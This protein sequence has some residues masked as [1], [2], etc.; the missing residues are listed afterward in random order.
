M[1]E[2]LCTTLFL[3]VVAAGVAVVAWLYLRHRA[4]HTVTPE[5]PY[6]AAWRAYAAARGYTLTV[7]A[8]T[9][10][11]HLGAQLQGTLDAVSFAV[12]T[13]VLRRNDRVVGFTRVKSRAAEPT[14]FSFDLSPRTATGTLLSHLFDATDPTL[15]D[16]A[17]DARFVLRTDDR[18]GALA[19]LDAPARAALVALAPSAQLSWLDGDATLTWTGFETN[20]D[21]LD[22]ACRAVVALCRWRRDPL[23]Y[24]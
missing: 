2:S 11:T 22:A 4:A 16:P 15:G 23:H 13:F 17:F 1:S 5:A 8:T 24:R 18:D 14:R 21:V 20:P 9:R 7:E 10:N 12:D 3:A 19:L 6:V